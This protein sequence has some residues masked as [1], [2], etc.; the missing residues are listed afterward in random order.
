MCVYFLRLGQCK[1]GSDCSYLH[2][3]PLPNG[4]I[5]DAVK[6]MQEELQFMTN[7]VKTKEMEINELKEKVNKLENIIMASKI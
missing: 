3:V 5:V 2:D 6:V 1:F 7:A 4:D